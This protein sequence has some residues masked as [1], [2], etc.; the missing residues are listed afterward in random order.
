[1]SRLRALHGELELLY[2]AQR[3]ESVWCRLAHLREA[4]ASMPVGVIRPFYGVLSSA[5][6]LR[7][8]QQQRPG[9]LKVG[10]F[11]FL[12]KLREDVLQCQQ[13][14]LRGGRIV[15]AAE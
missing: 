10:R 8:A 13:R 3:Y 15:Q 2:K 6:V 7:V 5:I 14:I 1:M 12:V 9:R 11:E 4:S